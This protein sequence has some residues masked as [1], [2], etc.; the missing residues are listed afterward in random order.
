MNSGFH[1]QTQHNGLDFHNI[2][3]VKSRLVKCANEYACYSHST[4]SL[5]NNNKSLTSEIIFEKLE[6]TNLMV[7]D[8]GEEMF[9]I[10]NYN[11]AAQNMNEIEVTPA[12]DY[13]QTLLLSGKTSPPELYPC[14]R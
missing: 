10:S 3:L 11:T 12:D 6:D 4:K 1:P 5:H 2:S 14:A 7:F 9:E 8:D 13:S